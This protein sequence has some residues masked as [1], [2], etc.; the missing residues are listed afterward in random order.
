MQIINFSHPLT[1]EQVDRI[2]RLADM[3]IDR[4]IDIPSQIDPA[5]PLEPQIDAMISQTGLTEI[6]WQ[7]LPLIINLPS[8]NCSAAMLLAKLH[9]LCGYFPAIIRLKPVPGSTTTCFE[10]AEVINLQRVR[11]RAGECRC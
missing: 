11:E 9:G 4:V 1:K 6:E 5:E 2:E 7:S 3:H 8:L 10:V